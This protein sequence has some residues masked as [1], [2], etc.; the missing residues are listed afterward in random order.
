MPIRS[1][2]DDS[3]IVTDAIKRLVIVSKN[4][5][6]DRIVCAEPSPDAIASADGVLACDYP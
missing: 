6:G 1:V 5:N 4:K 2:N 3:T